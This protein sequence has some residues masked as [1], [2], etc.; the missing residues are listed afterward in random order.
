VGK[1]DFVMANPP[2]N[3]DLVDAKRVKTD[4]RLPFGLPG[5]TR[6]ARSATGNYLW[7]S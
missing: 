4:P 5:V 7:M 1:C 3:V 2:V 6:R